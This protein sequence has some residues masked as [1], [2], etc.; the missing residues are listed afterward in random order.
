MTGI[1]RLWLRLQSLFLRERF[2]K[3]LDSEIQF[4]LDEQIAENVAAG[5][6]PEEARRAATRAFG[7]STLVKEEAWE[8]GTHVLMGR[9]IGVQ[10]AA[11][12]PNVA[13]VN[14]T[15]A[16]DLFPAGSNPIGRHFGPPGPDSTGDYAIGLGASRRQPQ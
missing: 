5:M 2:V 7:N 12:A 13:V 16:K 8:T 3:E 6:N 9:G 1:Q 10:D 4:H 15:F 14:Q 11:T